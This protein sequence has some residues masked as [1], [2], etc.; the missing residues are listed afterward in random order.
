MPIIILLILFFI[1]LIFGPQWWAKHT[2]KRYAKKQDHIP[3]TGGELARHLLDR[4]EMKEV[5]VEITEH[6][7]HYDPESRTVRL[8][9]HNYNDNS[10]TAVA[11]AAHEVG[12]AI[13]HHN[14]EAKLILRTRLI[15]TA[16]KIEK[17]GSIMMVVM[18][19]VMIVT[20]SPIVGMLLALAG[21]ATIAGSALIHL[22]TL[23]VEW[24]ASFG[25][26]LP[27][28]KQDYIEEKDHAA[29]ERIL[30]AA[31]LTYV[32]ASLASILNIWRWIALL[33]R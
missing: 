28:L 8:M 12:H 4:F 5:E 19:L 14:K 31:A 17:L 2:F 22:I 26:A 13:Q 11:V 6:G 10:L 25:K 15:K 33:K 16:Q 23:P 7:D 18:P 21:L 1:V 20:R 32:A 24:D 27:I 9:K 29:V 3:G 30:K